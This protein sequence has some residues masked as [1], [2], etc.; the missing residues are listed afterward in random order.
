MDKKQP[1]KIFEQIVK[2]NMTGKV[3]GKKMKHLKWKMNKCKLIIKC[4]QT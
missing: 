4:S 1:L 2:E 3:I